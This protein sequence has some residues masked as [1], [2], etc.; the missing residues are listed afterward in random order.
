MI[1]KRE[2]NEIV[3]NDSIIQ[4]FFTTFFLITD[5]DKKTC[6]YQN[7]A[8]CLPHF[9]AIKI[10]VTE[11]RNDRIFAQNGSLNPAKFL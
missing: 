6:N 10:F 4:L 3:K 2:K 11:C 8:A 9:L 1:T 5:Y 7:L